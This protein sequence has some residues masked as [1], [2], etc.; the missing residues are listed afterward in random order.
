MTAQNYKMPFLK[1]LPAI[2]C[3]G[4]VFAAAIVA[5]CG[6]GSESNVP[7]LHLA[8]QTV[9][10]ECRAEKTEFLKDRETTEIV[11]RLNGDATCPRGFLLERV[12]ID[13]LGRRK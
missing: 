8:C 6:S 7:Q 3:T 5:S 9:E 1:Y 11:W 4:F 2:R 12:E 13:F 10:C